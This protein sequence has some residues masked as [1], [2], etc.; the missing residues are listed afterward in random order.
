[1]GTFRTKV[2]V[3]N[4]VRRTRTAEVPGV[5]V[6]TG[7]EHLAIEGR[8]SSLPRIAVVLLVLG[9]AVEYYAHALGA[10]VV[11]EC[12]RSNAAERCRWPYRLSVA[13]IVLMVS[14]VT[15]LGLGLLRRRTD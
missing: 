2:D 9:I 6:D 10:F 13:G 8:R 14:G 15:A 1:M 3:A 5:L 12:G 11:T 7:A 4:I